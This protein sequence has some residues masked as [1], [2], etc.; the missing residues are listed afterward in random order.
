MDRADDWMVFAS[1]LPPQT[2]LMIIRSLSMSCSSMQYEN[3]SE[4]DVKVNQAE[5]LYRLY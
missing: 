3:C 4:C 1:A 2:L 5:P